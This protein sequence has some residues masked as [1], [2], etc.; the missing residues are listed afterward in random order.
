MNVHTSLHH[1]FII[2][3][4]LHP[5]AWYSLVH[6]NELPIGYFYPWETQHWILLDWNH[7]HWINGRTQ[8]VDRITLDWTFIGLYNWSLVKINIKPFTRSQL[9]R[10]D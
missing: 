4:T 2:D 5:L 3:H 1:W 7:P 10:S 9:L 6:W 8:N